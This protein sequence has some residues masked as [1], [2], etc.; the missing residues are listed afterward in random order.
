MLAVVSDSSPAPAQPRVGRIL[1]LDVGDRRIGVAVSDELGLTA[2]GV[3]TIHRRSWAVDL[4]EIA[5]LVGHWGAA[6]I[7]VGLPLTLEGSEGARA[8]IVR[9]FMK[10]LEGV[11]QVPVT[12]WDE[13]FSTVTAERV[14]IDAD[15]SRAKR[16]QVVDKTAAVVI[17]QH[18]LDTRANQAAEGGS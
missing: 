13:R 6:T 18:Y 10:R 4:A 1:A 14:L 8:G 16:R 2:Q 9:T 11:V 17:L 5:R 7:V 3:T 15:L 12:T